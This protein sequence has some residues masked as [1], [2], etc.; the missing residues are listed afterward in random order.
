MTLSII[1]QE[2]EYIKQCIL[3]LL[4]ENDSDD[5]KSVQFCL[6]V[7]RI[8]ITPDID[9]SNE[10]TIHPLYRSNEYSNWTRSTNIILSQYQHTKENEKSRM[11]IISLKVLEAHSTTLSN[12]SS[13]YLDPNDSIAYIQ[14]VD[15]SGWTF[16]R[17]IQSYLTSAIVHGYMTAAFKYL[18]IDW[19]IWY[20]T[21]HDIN[22]PSFIFSGS[23][24]N[25]D[26][27]KPLLGKN[28]AD[29]WVKIL[30][31]WSLIDHT[32]RIFIWSP[33]YGLCNNSQS[34]KTWQSSSSR[35]NYKPLNYSQ[36]IP[37]QHD[38]KAN[39]VPYF[40]D[41]PISRHYDTMNPIS[42]TMKEFFLSLAFRP[43][44]CCGNGYHFFIK[45]SS[46]TKNTSHLGICESRDIE[47]PILDFETISNA[48]SSSSLLLKILENDNNTIST[49]FQYIPRDL[50]TLQFT[51]QKI[52]IND[53][54]KNLKSLK[55]KAIQD[56]ESEFHHQ[57]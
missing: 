52:F 15:T 45:K 39:I 48:F 43:E 47:I 35:S 7:N 6:T 28:V 10:P 36:M 20:A 25:Q 14:Y 34:N 12:N 50:G 13:I 16:P 57:S 3:E 2:L 1:N 18:H 38:S 30:S 42:M 17:N 54:Q 11:A 32:E 21:G 41:D 5:P 46:I 40:P 27:K 51:T 53:L 31:T 26:Q 56:V 33:H 23:E 9:Q 44:Y 19:I 29:W 49:T 8:C 24:K 4:P 37:F 22:P 55:R